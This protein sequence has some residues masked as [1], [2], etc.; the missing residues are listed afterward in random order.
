MNYLIVALCNLLISNSERIIGKFVL[1]VIN[2]EL[3]IFLRAAV[4]RKLC[5]QIGKL[6][7]WNGPG[8]RVEGAAIV[9]GRR[10]FPRDETA[11]GTAP[12][13]VARRARGAR[14]PAL[15]RR[16]VAAFL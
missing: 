16:D 13:R 5:L 14:E 2:F 15:R 1:V 4:I 10:P 8:Q 9:A 12:L 11:A 7:F 6:R 3:I